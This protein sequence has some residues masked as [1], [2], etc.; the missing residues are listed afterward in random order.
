MI[1]YLSIILALI[2]TSLFYF[3]FWFAAMPNMNTKLI[4]A[5]VGLI[6]LGLNSS[7]DRSGILGKNLLS[8]LAFATIFSLICYFSIVY[9]GTTDLSYVTYF[10]SMSVWL[11]GAYAVCQIIKA[12]H[13][14]ISISHLSHYI[15]GVCVIQCF[16]ALLIDNNTSFKLLVDTHILQGQEFLTEVKRLYGIGAMLDTAGIRFSIALIL[17]S[18]LITSDDSK[19]QNYLLYIYLLA[20]A[21]LLIIGN[22]MARTTLVGVALGIILMI[23]KRM[24]YK[25]NPPFTVKQIVIGVLIVLMVVIPITTYF[26][27]TNSEIHA[28]L[29]FGFEGFFNLFEKGQWEVGSNG[30]LKGMVVFPESTKTWLIGDGYFNNPAVIDPYFTGRVMGGYYQ[31]TDI[32]YLRFIFYCGILGLIA[33]SLFICNAAALCIRRFPDKKILFLFLLLVNF[34]VWLK[35]STDIFLIF[36][37]FLAMEKPASFS[38]TSLE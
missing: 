15:I 23:Y 13:G 8:L 19:K 24:I 2:A 26:Y 38:T 32:G 4:L 21:I 36:A 34:I 3:P 11:A 25:D 9:N 33:F 12:V 17:L 22:M 7:R 18:Y 10:I 5:V 14:R 6:I 28:N 16:L 1:R 29:R 27:Q 31:G 35:V 20:F 37:L 30:Q